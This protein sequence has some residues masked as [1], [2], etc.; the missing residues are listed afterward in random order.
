MPHNNPALWAQWSLTRM[1]PAAR[2]ARVATPIITTSRLVA[3]RNS[4]E[5]LTMGVG[6]CASPLPGFT[7][8]GSMSAILVSSVLRGSA[9]SPPGY[10]PASKPSSKSD[11][12]AHTP[13]NTQDTNTGYWKRRRWGQRS[14]GGAG[15]GRRVVTRLK[16]L[17]GRKRRPSLGVAEKARCTFG[18]ERPSVTHYRVGVSAPQRS[19]AGTYCAGL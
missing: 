5:Y 17:H 19:W 12:C 2:E 10:C 3:K 16:D 7:S 11:V 4:S 1:A 13:S 18:N 8:S 15:R 14:V 9:A 6:G